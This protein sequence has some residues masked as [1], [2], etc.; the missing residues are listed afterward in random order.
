MFCVLYWAALC[1]ELQFPQEPLNQH[2]SQVEYL[3]A[4]HAGTPS[5][6]SVKG[7]WG[8]TARGTIISVFSE[9]VCLLNSSPNGSDMILLKATVALTFAFVS[10]RTGAIFISQGKHHRR[11]CRSAN[12][13][14]WALGSE[15]RSLGLQAQKSSR[16]HW[17][18]AGLKIIKW[19]GNLICS[20]QDLIM[21]SHYIQRTESM[22]DLTG[23]WWA[24]AANEPQGRN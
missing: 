13:Q 22:N 15:G 16:Y 20:F 3:P 24:V 8:I 10:E 4:T 21:A 7:R 5:A 6:T 14:P 17:Y 9:P 19:T 18:H 1:A 2:C 23:E 12:W 11:W